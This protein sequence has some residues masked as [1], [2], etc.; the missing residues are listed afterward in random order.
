MGLRTIHPQRGPWVLPRKRAPTF[1]SW[2]HV[3]QDVAGSRTA[4]GPLD[5]LVP[6][7]GVWLFHVK[8]RGARSV[9]SRSCHSVVRLQGRAWLARGGARQA[10]CPN[11]GGT[12]STE[13]APVAQGP[14]CRLTERQLSVRRT[15][16]AKQSR[17]ATTRVA[18][19]RLS[20]FEVMGWG[21]SPALSK[22]SGTTSPL[23]QSAAHC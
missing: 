20:S 17:P 6:R 11:D 15:S 19:R 12:R 16:P 22:G 8:H 9:R 3:A 14:R 10:G 5:R 7:H 2:V 23:V 21:V 13:T 18:R 4:A 1:R